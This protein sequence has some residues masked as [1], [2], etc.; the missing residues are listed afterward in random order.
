MNLP[1]AYLKLQ[2]PFLACFPAVGYPPSQ[3]D[4]VTWDHLV[5]KMIS[6]TKLGRTQI[7]KKKEFIILRDY[8]LNNFL[9]LTPQELQNA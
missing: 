9:K 3:G 6:L 8:M 1:G 2:L 7:E 5:Y 4:R